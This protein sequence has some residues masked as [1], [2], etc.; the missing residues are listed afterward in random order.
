MAYTAIAPSAFFADT[1]A[2][3]RIGRLPAT[4]GA[5]GAGL[6]LVAMSPILAPA[7][8]PMSILGV[9]LARRSG[10]H[11]A[12]A[13]GGLGVVLAMSALFQSGGAWIFLLALANGPF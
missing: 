7:S 12:L 5:V 1:L 2:E 6:G 11:R 13:I 10:D 4:V 3:A 8:V 9:V